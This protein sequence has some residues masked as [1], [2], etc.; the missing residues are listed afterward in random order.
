[1]LSLVVATL[2]FAGQLAAQSRVI[3]GKIADASGNPIPNASVIVKGTAN[4]TTS[5]ADGTYSLTVPASSRILTI[6][7]VGFSEVEFT[8]GNKAVINATLESADKNLQEVVVV[9]YGTQRKAEVTGS[10]ASVKGAVVADKPV[11]SFEAALGGRAAGVQITIPN[12]VLNNPPVFRIRGTNSISLSSYPLIVVDGIPTF[13]GDYSGTNAGANALASINP[14]DIES[15]DISKDAAASAIYGSRAANGVVFITTKKGKLGRAKVS[16]DGW[17]GWTTVQRLPDLLNAQQYTDF[18]NQALKNANTY[19]ATTNYFALTNDANGNP[20]NTRWYDYVY[21][22]GFSHSNSINVSGATESTNYYFSVGYTDQEGIVRKNDFKRKNILFNIDHRAN[23]V[24]SVGAKV[25][26]SNEQNLAATSSGSLPG[27]AFST[28][29]LGRVAVVTAPNVSPYNNDG[30]YNINSAS[31]SL[32]GSMNNKQSQI[33]FYNP[34]ISLDKNKSN[35]ESNHTQANAYIQIKPFNWLAYKSVYGIDYLYLDN[36][37]Y[38]DPISGE[39]Y[40]TTGY[41][42]SSYSKN[43]RSVW[44]NT[45]SFDYTIASK[46]TIGLLAGIEEQR[47]NTESF[48]LARQTVS[49]PYFTNIQGGWGVNNPASMNIGQNYLYSQF[50]RFN[51]NYDKKYYLSANLRQDEYSGLGYNARKGTFWGVSAGWE[52]NRE[53]FWNSAH[54]D[55][56]FSSFKLRGSYGKVGNIGGIGNF[57]SYTSYGSGLYGGLATLNFSGAGNTNLTWETSKKLD[58]GFSFGILNERVTGE[59]S[60]YKNNIDGLIL[61]VPQIP[62]AGIPNNSLR[63][64]VGSM[65]NK[66]VEFTLNATPVST[67]DF[68]W[69][70]SFNIGINKNEVTSL[71]PGIPF[72]IIT[73]PA[74]ASTNEAV[75][76]TQPGY[77]IGTLYLIPTK[78]VDPQTG[79]RIY[80][81]ASGKDVYYSHPGLWQ[82]A[83]G[84]TASAI[85][86]TDRRIAKNTNPKQYGG[87][88]NTFRYKDFE[89]NVLLTY[90]L[91]F[92]VYYGTEAGLRD[93]RFWNNETAVLRAWTKP[94]DVTDIPKAVFGDNY[95]NGSAIPLDVHMYK[96]N[97][98]KLRNITLSYN[99]PKK[100][101]E[102]AKFSSARFYVSGQNL[103]IWT[104]YPGPDPETSTNGNGPANQGIDRNQVANGR[105]ITVGVKVGL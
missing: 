99:V 54:L 84:S 47:T 82:Y 2:L 57:E 17:V 55:K 98:M 67:K 92:Y 13:T 77:S 15:I 23:K 7:A 41:A 16:Y 102:K 90:Q 28:G 31:P 95:S 10:L 5:T 40:S 89:M 71:A 9:G 18:K 1:M 103:A 12:G 42:A 37:V 69:N 25:A 64:N 46:H 45:L 72:I 36:L 78:G 62:S 74:G 38:Y 52:I 60:Y 94:G 68:S 61:D 35:S 32:I 59:F 4:G 85:S 3:T 66:G 50:G 105:T 24:L 53:N 93:M 39:G 100:L 8:I 21:R 27:E 30:S 63:G 96:G 11:Q 20:I 83:D 44:T 29:G 76:I 73:S 33:G 56:V 58:V 6:S 81:N 86:T 48:G 26:Y 19:N 75:S 97:F 34:V 49:D 43:K 87:F 101:L 51:Y 91:G 22:T 70:T 88:D 65:Y 79:R 104:K 80:V 14:S